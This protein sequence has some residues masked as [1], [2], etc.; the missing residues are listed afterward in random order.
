M[1]DILNEYIKLLEENSHLTKVISDF[2]RGKE[3]LAKQIAILQHNEFHLKSAEN[4]LIE[5]DK[6]IEVLEQIIKGQE[7]EIKR[8]QAKYK[9]L[10]ET[11]SNVINEFNG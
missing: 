10:I 9:D 2:A 7:S 5:K 3:M 11:L 8:I 4:A 6:K 1:K